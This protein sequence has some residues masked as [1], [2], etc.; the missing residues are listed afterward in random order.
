[1][2]I[3]G[4]NMPA[5]HEDKTGEGWRRL[6]GS[7]VHIGEGGIIDAGC[8]GL[9]GEHI[10][11][12]DDT[13]DERADR[14]EQAER[15]GWKSQ[16]HQDAEA[17]HAQIKPDTP[18]GSIALV[19]VG[20]KYHTFGDDA[21]HMQRVL[22]MG[23]GQ[24]AEFDHEHLEQHLKDLVKNGHRVAIVE[25]KQDQQ[26]PEHK[27]HVGPEHAQAIDA[28]QDQ[29]D[30]EPGRLPDMEKEGGQEGE[31]VAESPDPVAEHLANAP[32]KMRHAIEAIHHLSTSARSWN[33]STTRLD[34]IYAQSL[35]DHLSN[36]PGHSDGFGQ[37]YDLSDH[38]GPGAIGYHS[39]AGVLALV[40]PQW[41]GEPWEA[42]YSAEQSTA[43]EQPA[44][45]PYV[46]PA[47]EPE[48]DLFDEIPEAGDS[49]EP[50]DTTE[51]T[52]QHL[53][54]LTKDHKGLAAAVSEAFPGNVELQ[55][56]AADMAL[57]E[58]QQHHDFNEEFKRQ[59]RYLLNSLGGKDWGL[60]AARLKQAAER[61]DDTA[62]AIKGFVTMAQAYQHEAPLMF[63]PLKWDSRRGRYV[64]SGGSGERGQ[65]L[66]SD[67]TAALLDNL[68]KPER[69]FET[70]PPEDYR[71]LGAA[72]DELDRWK[73]AASDTEESDQEAVPF[74]RRGFARQ[75]YAQWDEDK[76]P[77]D[78]K[79]QF[80]LEHQKGAVYRIHKKSFAEDELHGNH[81]SKP[82]ES[83]GDD[84]MDAN[85]TREGLSASPSLD[86][87][88][89]YF[90]GF[91]NEHSPGRGANLQGVHVVQLTGDKSHDKPWE[92]DY[93]E[94]LIHPNK[95]LAQM[96]IE[97]TDFIDR[98]T[99]KI[100]ERWGMG[101]HG[102]GWQYR[103]ERDD[104]QEK[105]VSDLV[106]G[107]QL[108]KNG[109]W[110]TSSKEKL[111]ATLP[112]ALIESL[113]QSELKADNLLTKVLIASEENADEEI[114]TDA[115]F[116]ID[117]AVSDEGVSQ[118]AMDALKEFAESIRR[119]KIQ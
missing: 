111:Q 49:Y 56:A 98:V 12:L 101:E 80:V 36:M 113:N 29:E 110:V 82:W 107:W 72:L 76:H 92:K 79:G 65:S 37:V 28:D 44:T 9:E 3:L 21:Q 55:A 40:P 87:L 106:S 33:G 119:H 84:N 8:P 17:A 99:R 51:A 7:A 38:L 102:L 45:S 115:Q 46:T 32:P 26:Q 118:E 77:R 18:E 73:D 97:K 10:E 16:D 62:S 96:P 85:V 86:A 25:R 69:E 57:Q 116:D 19:R 54:E 41:Q 95:I 103:A 23:D 63:M 53:A 112:P 66:D 24:H 89:G 43:V 81:R 42:R 22:G 52:R 114:K 105:T 90:A 94:V 15:A 6:G 100:E 30:S 50:A 70:P 74:S 14:Q 20:G 117:Y 27:A 67:A 83:F 13:R 75:R 91:P 48:R 71:F 31:Q 59:R 108:N 78:E 39:P 93:G 2:I 61:G 4:N 11:H 5:A 64:E 35:H 88:A 109:E 104:F 68:A 60:R 1:M 58:W 47:I 34:P